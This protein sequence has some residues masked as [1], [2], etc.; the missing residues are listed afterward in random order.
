MTSYPFVDP[1]EGKPEVVAKMVD[2][3]FHLFSSSSASDSTED[4]LEELDY[5]YPDRGT[6]VRDLNEL[7]AITAHGPT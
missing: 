5:P 6:F 1:V 2:G 7:L 3:V 4:E